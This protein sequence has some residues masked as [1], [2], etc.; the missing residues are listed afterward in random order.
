LVKVVLLALPLSAWA[1]DAP[2][3]AALLAKLADVERCVGTQ[4]GCRNLLGKSGVLVMRSF[5]ANPAGARGSEQLFVVS[6]EQLPEKGLVQVPREVPISFSE[7]FASLAIGKLAWPTRSRRPSDEKRCVMDAQGRFCAT[8]RNR[9]LFRD[10]IGDTREAAAPAGSDFQMVPISER[11]WLLSKWAVRYSGFPLGSYMVL[12][13]VG[14]D[15]QVSALVV[16]L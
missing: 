1:S 5:P 16:L 12:S 13:Q 7:E 6:R 11:E 8:A 4:S 14:K 3:K 15:W 10:L 2:E 9:H